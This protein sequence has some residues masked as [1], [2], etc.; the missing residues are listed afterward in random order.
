MYVSLKWIEQMVGLRLLSLNLLT[1]R[2]ILAGFEIDSLKKK[3]NNKGKIDIILEISITANRSDTANMKGF[4]IELCSLVNSNLVFYNPL[5][6]KPLFFSSNIN[7]IGRRLPFN[8]DKTFNYKYKNYLPFYS[9]SQNLLFRYALWEHYQQKKTFSIQD[10]A[11]KNFLKYSNWTLPFIKGYSVKVTDS[12]GWIKKRLNLMNFKSINNITDIINYILIET[13]QVFFVYDISCLTPS[14]NLSPLNLSLNYSALNTRFSISK[15]ESITLP[16]NILTLYLDKKPLSVFGV[17]QDFNTLITKKTSQFILQT[18]LVDPAEVKNST[19]ILGL[20]TE[21]SLKLEKRI[22][23][24]LFEQ[25]YLRLLYLFK[26][27]KI[28]LSNSNIKVSNVLRRSENLAFFSTYLHQSK[29]KIFFKNIYNIIGTSKSSKEFQNLEIL[30]NLRILNFNILYKTDKYVIL[31]IPLPR[32]SDIEQEIDIIEEVVRITGFNSFPSILPNQNDLGK[33]TKFE[34]LK[35]RIRTLL[36]NFGFHESLHSILSKKALKNQI[37]LKNP[38]FNESSALRVSLLNTLL[39]KIFFNK[40]ITRESFET[41]E[42]GRV[43]K[44]LSMSS[45]HKKQELE[46]LSGIFGGKLFRSTWNEQSSIINW[47][48]AK[49]LLENLFLKMAISIN[50]LPTKI[51][52]NTLFHPTR[53]ANIFIGSQIIGTFGQLHPVLSFKTGLPKQLYLFEF[54]IN[55]LQRFWKSK[56]SITYLPYSSYP[57]SYIDLSCVTKKNLCFKEIER[58]IFELGQPLLDSIDLFDYYSKPPIKEGFCSLS[59]KLGFTSRT[60]TLLNTE[61]NNI[62]ETIIYVLEENFEIEFN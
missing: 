18:N 34:K 43:Y 51:K 59:F 55:I 5:N 25:A 28:F 13:G 12:P 57:V 35:R 1:N 31:T 48:E 22:D 39:E 6:M 54:N 38:L 4:L 36:V 24:N 19:N 52:N 3:K 14:E 2:L 41:F 30:N 50:Y 20:K 8:W 17:I 40:K 23:L 45:I 37:L 46:L 27:Q 58:K 56:T 47:F 10:L 16:N 15:L 33:L 42:L 11:Q 62:V 29:I 53:T 32:K 9:S 61:V 21:Y 49:G 44:F 60:R 26:T 7:T